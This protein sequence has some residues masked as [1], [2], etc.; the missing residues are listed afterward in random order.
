MY[1]G[2]EKDE[3]KYILP[4]YYLLVGK[5]SKDGGE[6]K[7]TKDISTSIKENALNMAGKC[8]DAFR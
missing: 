6:I 2:K 8:S 5:G 3:T 1:P 4:L 7:L